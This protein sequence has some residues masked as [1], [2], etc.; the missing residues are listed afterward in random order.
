[1]EAAAANSNSSKNGAFN[2]DIQLIHVAV[3]QKIEADLP[4]P[5]TPQRHP[6][7]AVLPDSLW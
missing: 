4:N 5:Q 1:M 3:R 7:T 2:S 6:K